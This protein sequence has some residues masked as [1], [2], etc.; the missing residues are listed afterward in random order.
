LG[1][2]AQRQAAVLV[3]NGFPVVVA[4]KGERRTQRQDEATGVLV[5]EFDIKGEDSW[6]NP[7]RGDVDSYVSF[8]VESDFDIILMNAWQTWSTDLCLKNM[9][10]I[11]GRKVLYSNCLSTNVFFQNQPLRSL[12]RYLLWRPY[13]WK[14]PERLRRL[15][16]FIVTAAEG[17]DSRFDD[18]RVAQRLGLPFA[19]VPNVLSQDSLEY[20]Q[21]PLVEYQYRTQL[22]A[23]GSYTWQKGH[24]FVLRS[25][26][27]SKAKNRVPLKV[28]GQSFTAFTNLLR[29]LA[30]SLGIRDE[31]LSFHEGVSGA[32]LVEEYTHSVALLS[33]SHT[34]C[35]PLVLLDSMATGTPF[36]ARSTGCISTLAGGCG[37]RTECEAAG[38]IDK[39]I[40]D[41]GEWARLS[42]AGRDEAKLRH[43]PD[44]VGQNLVAVLS[45]VL[46]R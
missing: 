35:Q 27:L 26:A 17:C 3:S 30:E 15:D 5:E 38:E 19:V 37:V 14:L 33:G 45:E 8:L 31:Y 39:L 40:T 42:N 28:F 29:R 22:I 9:E 44:K 7:I 4:T 2:A 24:D 10:Q 41:D 18:L 20:L 23:V 1:N 11:P 34:E 6:L 36:V 12:V 25:Y 43:H 13:W 21:Q 46:A 16:G 32:T